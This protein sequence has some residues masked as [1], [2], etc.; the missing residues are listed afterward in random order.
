MS[1]NCGAPQL[2][3]LDYDRVVPVFPEEAFKA[4]VLGKIKLAFIIKTHWSF[5]SEHDL[6][7]NKLRY[8]VRSSVSSVARFR[9]KSTQDTRSR[10]IISHH[11]SVSSGWPVITEEGRKALPELVKVHARFVSPVILPESDN[12][13]T[14]PKLLEVCAIRPD[15]KTYAVLAGLDCCYTFLIHLEH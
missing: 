2:A 6:V 14:Y 7:W 9:K 3:S 10:F 8:L 13:F 4:M 15:P 11:S 1:A 5:H 12:W